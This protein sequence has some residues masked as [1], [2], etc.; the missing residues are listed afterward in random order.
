MEINGRSENLISRDTQEL[1]TANN[2]PRSNIH[3]KRDEQN[4]EVRP[5]EIMGRK[6]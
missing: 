2:S 4:L 3:K 6:H 5:V 1:Q